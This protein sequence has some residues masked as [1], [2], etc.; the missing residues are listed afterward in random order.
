VRRRPVTTFCLLLCALGRLAAG[1]EPEAVMESAREIPVAYEVDV[2]VVGGSTGAVAAAVAAAREGT[3]V[4]LAA[5][6]TY[7]GEDMVAPLRLWLEPKEEPRTPLAKLLFVG[8]AERA[9]ASRLPQGLPFT[10]ETGRPSAPS[11]RDTSPLS[12]L[13]DRRYR[14]AISESVQYDG[15]V[16][17]TCD[18]GELKQVERVHLLVYQRVDDFEVGRVAVLVSPDGADWSKAA[19]GENDLVGAR[20]FE[21]DPLDLPADV[22][23]RTRYVRF[24]VEPAP[25]SGRVLLAEIVIGGE[26][27]EPADVPPPLRVATP[28][29]VERTLEEALMEAGV[30]FLF[31]CYATDLVRDADGQ[32]AGIV[33][34]NRAGRQAVL[35]RVI[36]D[37]TDRATVA[38]MAGAASGHYPAGRHAFRRAIIGRDA[39]AAEGVTVRELR[40]TLPYRT[41]EQ[42]GDAALLECILQLPMTDGSF[43]SFASAEQAARDRT[44][45]ASQ[46]RGADVLFQVPPDPVVGRAQ[47]KGEW[48]GADR[49]DLDAFRPAD[50]GRLYVLGGCADLPRPW[51]EKLLRPPALM[52]AGERIGAAAAREAAQLPGPQGAH[53]TGGPSAAPDMGEV[54]EVL[55]GIRAT[56]TLPRIPQPERPLPVLG[57]YD[58]VVVG[59]GTSG[60]PAA[61]AAARQGAS[62]L[63]VEYQHGL[64]GVSTLGLI[65]KYYGGYRG[66]F[67]AEIDKGVGSLGGGSVVGK[68]EWYRREIRRAGGEIWFGA[69]GCGALVHRGRVRGVIVATPQGRGVVLTETAVDSTGNAD[70]ASAA[71]ANCIYTDGAFLAVQ[72]AGLP[73]RQLGA[74]YTNTD[75]TFIDE[76]DMMDV[77]RVLVAARRKYRNSFDLAP[78]LD[79]RER[80]RIVGDFVLSPWDVFA[81]RTYPD[82]I[83]QSRT[84][85]DTH[86]FT[87]DLLFF[88]QPPDKRGR[89][90]WTPYRC[91]LPAGLEGILVTGLGTSAHRD[92]VPFIRMQPDL[93]NQGY[94]AGVAAAM[95][96]RLDGKTRSV[97]VRGL[98]EHLVETGNLPG[99]VLEHQDSFPLPPERLAEAVEQPQS[100]KGISLI[101]AHSQ[102]ALP[103]LR[104]AHGK[105]RQADRILYARIL[106]LL[107]D[108]TGLDALI[109]AV[110]ECETFDEGWDFRG[111]GQYGGSVSRLDGLIIAL[112]RTGDPRALPPV[113]SKLRLLDADSEFSHHRAVALALEVLGDPV[114]AAP[115]AETLR[116][117]G[118]AGHTIRGPEIEENRSLSLREIVLA[119]ALYRL[120]DHEGVARGVLEGYASDLRGHFARHAHAI[121]QAGQGAGSK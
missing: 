46:L 56:Q 74:S 106:G 72:G 5:P 62:V 59:G 94:A 71:G 61:I 32:P 11:H 22:N 93:Q 18:L 21:T 34:A 76:T 12:R 109:Q 44:W 84:D 19:T 65:G 45:S 29:Q 42:S 75:Y 38:R 89:L 10:Y 24:Q 6:R 83:G 99:E 101:L 55:T 4:F 31:G 40:A 9:L 69:L 28:M 63:V 73:P 118:I 51:A 120:G 20:G 90:A 86:G 15:D 7:L 50:V 26:E 35:A 91:L 97:D 78:L 111:M 16:A 100:L 39:G 110:D 103:L 104:E 13:C 58:V 88:I 121:L 119:R 33:M 80:R 96:A 8:A 82:T 27:Q 87:V 105:T 113:L 115:L 37:A 66:G 79:T 112:G 64:G 92:A 70:I 114:A 48:P 117:P 60:A 81:E 49:V 98:Q 68:M 30:R 14:S 116:K 108:A 2:V 107:G 102:A 41:R 95:A 54:M 52:E 53:V 77:W 43:A 85:Y 36:I 57:R 17:I 47:P 1:A 3:S 25:G 23:A 67:T